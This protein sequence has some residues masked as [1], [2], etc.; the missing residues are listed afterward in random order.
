MIVSSLKG[1]A[2]AD[3]VRDDATLS[4]VQQ[5]HVQNQDDEA[6]EDPE[7][8]DGAHASKRARADVLE[9]SAVERVALDQA[10]IQWAARR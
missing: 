9:T 2:L 3:L 7:D 1:I 10:T 6:H 8:D 4:V 5:H